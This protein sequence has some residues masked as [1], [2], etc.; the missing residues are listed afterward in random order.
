MEHQRRALIGVVRDEVARSCDTDQLLRFSRR[1]IYEHKLLIPQDRA[2]RSRLTNALNTLER[3][4]TEAIT[5]ELMQAVAD[6]LSLLANLV[7][8]WNTMQVLQGWANRR[9]YLAPELMGKIA[10]T[11][12]EGIN[13]RSVF[14]FPTERYAGKI[15]PSLATSIRRRSARNRSR[16]DAAK[17]ITEP[18]TGTPIQSNT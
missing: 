14:R 12:I 16:V 8:A 10:P 13:L 2:L 18:R 7:M 11:R 17:R 1:W 9:Q 6:A 15:V 5:A 4:T 3:E